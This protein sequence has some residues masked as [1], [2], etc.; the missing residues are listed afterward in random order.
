MWGQP[1]RRGGC[2]HISFQPMTSTANSE[3]GWGSQHR[4]V[5]A[6]KWKAK[7]A[8]M[9]QAVTDVLLECAHPKPGMNVLDLASGT[10]E[11][12]ISLA[13]RVGAAGHVTALDLSADLLD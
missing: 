1:C 2:P 4:L 5:A 10:G 3:P 8:A 9:G 13:L 12:A 6:E 11:P 7:S